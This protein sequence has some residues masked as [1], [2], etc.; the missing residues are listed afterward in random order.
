M[1]TTESSK[2]TPINQI[3]IFSIEEEFA[4]QSPTGEAS[5]LTRP[6]FNQV[7]AD[8]LEARYLV[9]CYEE[10]DVY[11]IRVDDTYTDEIVWFKASDDAKDEPLSLLEDGYI[12][13]GNGISILEYLY[14]LGMIRVTN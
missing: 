3:D 12:K 8:K 14:N 13:W 11:S 5:A 10:W 6:P 7:V 1:K 2:Q 9:S 4:N